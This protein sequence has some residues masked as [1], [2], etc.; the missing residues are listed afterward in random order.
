LSP[1][2]D[3][4][5]GKVSLDHETDH[6]YHHRQWQDYWLAVHWTPQ[7]GSLSPVIYYNTMDKHDTDY[8]HLSEMGLTI[9]M[10]LD[11]IWPNKPTQLEGVAWY[12]KL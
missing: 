4:L 7:S 11:N 5:S 1:V 12:I 9:T 6:G 3:P 2:H 10:S 8:E